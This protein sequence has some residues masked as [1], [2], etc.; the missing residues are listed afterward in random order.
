MRHTMLNGAREVVSAS[1]PGSLLVSA[2]VTPINAV[3]PRLTVTVSLRVAL[4]SSQ[5]PAVAYPGGV[6][7][8]SRSSAAL[9]TIRSNRVIQ[10]LEPT[11][12]S[13]RSRLDG[14]RR[15]IRY[16]AERASLIILLSN[17]ILDPEPTTLR[18]P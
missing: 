3:L 9:T 11:G 12:R 8:A 7:K 18:H 4:V 13:T 1:R 15:A 17:I 14:M 10:V 2:L 6:Y 16:R 5:Q